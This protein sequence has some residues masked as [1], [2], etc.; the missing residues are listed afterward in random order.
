M[1]KK[2]TRAGASAR[3][4][5]GLII[6]NTGDGKGKTSAALGVALRASGYGMKVLMIQFFKGKWKY[7]ELRSAPKLQTF[8]ILPM[9]KGFTWESDDIEIDKSMVRAAWVEAR[10]RILSGDY[11]VVILDEINYARLH[12]ELADEVAPLHREP[13]VT[14]R[15]EH[16]GVGIDRSRIRHRNLLD[17]TTRGIQTSDVCRAIA[18]VPDHPIRI[19]DQVVRAGALL[20]LVAFERS[21]RRIEGSDIVRPLAHKPH[22]PAIRGERVARSRSLTRNFPLLEHGIGRIGCTREGQN[23]ERRENDG[24]CPRCVDESHGHSGA[25]VPRGTVGRSQNGGVSDSSS[26]GLR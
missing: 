11:A 20:E 23:N 12:G 25:W 24:Y 22:E 21:A 2:I 9:G 19:D 10:K 14:G 26:T 4:Q 13:D 7:G 1:K 16:Q 8:E 15:I 18:R 5:K 6:V 17:L 3:K